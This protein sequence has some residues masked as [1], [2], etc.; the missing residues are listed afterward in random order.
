MEGSISNG[1]GNDHDNHSL[2]HGNDND[3]DFEIVMW[4]V[5]TKNDR[6]RL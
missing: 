6:S 5:T 2:I 3:M 4:Q 1:Y